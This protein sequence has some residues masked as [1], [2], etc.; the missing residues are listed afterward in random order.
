MI[1]EHRDGGIYGRSCECGYS[2]LLMKKVFEAVSFGQ[3]L[4]YGAKRTEEKRK[5]MNYG[6]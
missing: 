1:T 5:Q 6:K 4:A 2:N 3:L